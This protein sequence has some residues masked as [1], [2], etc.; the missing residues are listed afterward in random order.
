MKNLKKLPTKQLEKFSN[1]FTQ[2]GLVLVLFIVYI[3]LE[4][5]TVQKTIP[6]SDVYEPETVYIE[7]DRVVK[8]VKEVKS[9]PKK[10]TP[11]KVQKFFPDEIKKGDNDLPEIKIFNTSEEDPQ[12]I[13]IE[14]VQVVKIENP[15]IEDVDFINI[16]NAPIFKGCEGLTEEKNKI[17]FER[18]M[19]QFVQRNF[20]IDLASDLGLK[21]G[22]HKI[23]TQFVIDKKGKI[24][25]LKVKATHKQLEREANRIILKIPKFTPGKQREKPVRVKYTLP[26]LFNIQ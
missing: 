14:N 1:I 13:D 21:S 23:Y 17:C 4:H 8:F 25:D 19:K 3:T 20:D 2:L 18:K 22:N 11:K 10:Q 6:I 16:Q 26:I 12:L 7:P 9:K 5:Q 15:I 24:V